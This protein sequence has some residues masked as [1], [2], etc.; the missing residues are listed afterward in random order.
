MRKK[1]A[2]MLSNLKKKRPFYTELEYLESTGTQYIDTGYNINTSTDEVETYFQLITT[3]KYKWLMGEHDNGAG[4][5]I[6]SGDGT[7]LRNIAYGA[8]T[9]KVNDTEVYNSQHYFNANSNGV[10]V[11][12]TQVHAFESFTSTSTVYLFNLNISGG[13]SGASGKIWRYTQKRNGVLIRDMIPV[14]DWDMTP[15]MYD[16]VSGQFFYN[17]GTGTFSYGREI[18]YV[19]YLEADGTQYINTGLLS[20]ALSQVSVDFSLAD[21]TK[22]A[23]NNV[24]I[25]GGRVYTTSQTFTYF[26]L[27]STT[28]QYFRFDF[29]SQIQVGDGS[30]LTINNTS[31]YRFTYDG[32]TMR[33]TNLTTGETYSYDKGPSN[34]YTTYPIT[35]FGVNTQG[36]IGTFLKGKVYHYWYT[37]GTNTVD[38][39]PAIDENGVGFMFD[40]VNHTIYDNVGTGVFKYPARETEY[41]E[42]TDLGTANNRP[43]L[44]L[45][46]K[47]KSSMSIEGK[48]TRTAQGDSGSVLPLSNNTTNPL[49]YF[50]ALSAGAMIDRFVFRRNGYSEQRKDK[51]FSSYPV[52]TEFKLDAVNDI[53]Y[54]DGAVAKTGMIAGMGGYTSPYESSSNLY[55]L[56]IDGTYGGMGKVYPLKI[57]DTEQVYRDLVPAFKDG[58]IGMYDK[59]HGVFYTNTKEGTII[60]GK[61]VEPEYE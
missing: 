32:T 51:T 61:I 57:Y 1:L 35:I 43:C 60:G 9:Y 29:N 56:S 53:L 49:I 26:F 21:T 28:P 15:C 41:I 6:G 3:N 23:N 17:A 59:E 30:Q 45:G 58:S 25:F 10:Y 24:A 8:S 16:K 38:M 48:Y 22:N 11:N 7:N 50:P 19:D 34:L 44:N 54:I 4:F 42:V 52:T 2:L 31:K 27:A 55:M 18:H 46:L 33:T 12:G 40:R 36:T 39:Y 14:L 13:G 5:C 47:Y 37:D 20:T